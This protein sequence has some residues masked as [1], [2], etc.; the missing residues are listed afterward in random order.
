MIAHK[1]GQWHTT[2]SQSLQEQ[3]FYIDSDELIR[4]VSKQDERRKGEEKILSQFPHLKIIYEEDLLSSRSH[5]ETSDRI[6]CY[7]DV[8]SAPVSTKLVRTG[9][10]QLSNY[11]SNYDEIDR[12]IRQ[13]QYAHLLDLS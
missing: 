3:L 12:K 13:T 7:L 4:N 8:T 11:I 6:F 1:R 10:D 2:S 9:S 5:Q